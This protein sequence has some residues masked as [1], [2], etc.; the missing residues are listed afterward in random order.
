MKMYM[1]IVHQS[2]SAIRWAEMSPLCIVL[3][4]VKKLNH[5][6]CSECDL[7]MYVYHCMFIGFMCLYLYSLTVGKYWQKL[8]MFRKPE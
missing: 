5:Y 1:Y 3:Q 4:I 8:A 2:D 6:Q 7:Y